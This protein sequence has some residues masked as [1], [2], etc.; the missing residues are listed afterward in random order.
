MSE[1]SAELVSCSGTCRWYAEPLE[2]LDVCDQSWRSGTILL[3]GLQSLL[4]SIDNISCNG[5]TVYTTG[6]WQ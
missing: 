3:H 2:L 4:L 5:V 1:H 6:T